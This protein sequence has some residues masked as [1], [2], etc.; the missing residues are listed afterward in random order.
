VPGRRGPEQRRGLG[1]QSR[2]GRRVLSEQLPQ[3]AG[4]HPGDDRRD[5]FR[6]RLQE[7]RSF[8]LIAAGTQGPNGPWPGAHPT[9]HDPAGAR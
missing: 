4:R 1:Q 9:S 2:D 5:R 8:R 3:G 6:D 7:Q